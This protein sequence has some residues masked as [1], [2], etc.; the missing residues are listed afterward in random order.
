MQAF[1]HYFKTGGYLDFSLPCTSHLFSEENWNASI[2]GAF[3]QSEL[4]DMDKDG[5]TIYLYDDLMCAKTYVSEFIQY[6]DDY[7]IYK[8]IIGKSVFGKYL[9]EDMSFLIDTGMSKPFVMT[10]IIF[11][12]AV[13]EEGAVWYQG[14]VD[15][16]EEGDGIF[17][18]MSKLFKSRDSVV[19]WYNCLHLQYFNI[20]RGQHGSK[21]A[22]LLDKDPEKWIDYL[23][24]YP[25]PLYEANDVGDIE[26]STLVKR[27]VEQEYNYETEWS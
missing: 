11:S 27:F 1:R 26:T 5:L 13:D 22:E 8:S 19:E 15:N 23:K 6:P 9:N 10:M 25:L 3:S 12:R 7:K 20:L 17:T 18:T 21:Y 24:A 14:L 16:Y 2:N 4:I